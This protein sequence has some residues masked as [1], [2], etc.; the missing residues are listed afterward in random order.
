MRIMESRDV[1]RRRYDRMVENPAEERIWGYW[2]DGDSELD[3][4]EWEEANNKPEKK[5]RAGK[6]M[7]RRILM[8]AEEKRKALDGPDSN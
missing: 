7:G 3:L 1:L 2:E 6:A 5:R 4:S 8:E